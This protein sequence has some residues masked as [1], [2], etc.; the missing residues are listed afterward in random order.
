MTVPALLLA[1]AATL[2]WSTTWV[3][4]KAGVDRMD[5]TTLGFL[6]PWMGLLF[7]VPYA[8]ATNGFVFGSPSLVW[9]GLGSGFLN[10]FLG[11]ALFYFALSQGSMHQTNILAG[12]NPFWGALSAIL[13]LNEPARGSTF[14]AAGLIVAGTYFLARRSRGDSSKAHRLLPTLAALGA[15]VLWGFT[16]AVPSKYCIMNGMSPIAYQLLFTATGAIGWTL[17]AMPRLVRRTLAISRKGVW[18]ALVSAFTGFFVGWVFWL[19]AMRQ[20]D[21]SAL[22]PLNGLTLFFA[23]LLGALF[24]KQRITLRIALGGALMLAGVTVISLFG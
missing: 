2:C 7:I 4:M 24:F 21:A 9:I 18:I 15:G 10:A 19:R 14:I 20:V 8:W 13:I 11:V 3:L 5:R 22:A 16:V 23:V 17:V 6:R 1:L 12:T